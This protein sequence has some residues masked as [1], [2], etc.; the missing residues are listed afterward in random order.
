MIC[1]NKRSN[2]LTVAEF[3]ESFDDFPEWDGPK[4]VDYFSFFLTGIENK[5]SFTAN[6]IEA[7]F[8][9]AHMR[10]YSRVAPYVSEQVSKR[11][12]KYIKVAKGYRLERS[13]YEEIRREV[14]DEP[15][16]IAVS[17]RLSELLAK[18]TE[19]R[20]HAFLK[21]AV[22]CYRVKAFRATIILV[23]IL[24]INHLHEWVFKEKL[25]EFNS[26]LAKNPDKKVKAVSVID[27]FSDISES[28]FIEL[29]RAA[30]LISADVR[31]ILD[32]K[33][34]IRNSAAHPSH[35]IFDSH[36]ATEF[37]SD[38]VENVLLKF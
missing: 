11:N 22:D 9:A 6:D 25:V 33:L 31:R 24:V 30:G 18:V 14:E 34:G 36:K 7:C 2:K 32:E 21:E 19:P 10:R 38:L 5:A 17:R 13:T 20:E 16:K 12:G 28:K 23:W 8:N 35:I 4:Q 29:L 3:V 1:Q 26:A 37:T 15:K 27:E